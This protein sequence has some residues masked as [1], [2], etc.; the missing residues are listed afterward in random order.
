MRLQTCAKKCIVDLG[1]SFQTRI[2]VQNLALVEPR[3]NPL[4]FARSPNECSSPRSSAKA[5]RAEVTFGQAADSERGE[6]AVP[7]GEQM[8]PAL[9]PQPMVLLTPS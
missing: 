8:F 3:T 2:H 5:D 1:E 6:A 7:A 9:R 4:K